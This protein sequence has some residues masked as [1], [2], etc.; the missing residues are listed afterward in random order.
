M[1]LKTQ[2]DEPPTMNLTSM[3]DVALLLV[4]FFMV[5]TRFSTNEQK[6][7][8]NVPRVGDVKGLT[9]TPE[10]KA[11]NIYRD[12]TITFGN[13]T[14]TDAELSVCLAAEKQR[15]PQLSVVV[16]GDAEVPLQRF[17]DV[18][19]ACRQSGVSDIGVSVKL[20]KRER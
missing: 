7:G 18:L 6:I 13:E 10:K 19:A 14:V 15:N 5:A 9:P 4:I 11:V 2:L 20:A 17:T 1:P 3:I 16:R 8:L 12:S